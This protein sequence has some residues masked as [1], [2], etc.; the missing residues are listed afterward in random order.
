MSPAKPRA[1]AR[2]EVAPRPGIGTFAV[3]AL[4]FLLALA[5]FSW[6]GLMWWDGGQG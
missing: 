2:A 1:V 5:L 4:G 3:M 6:F